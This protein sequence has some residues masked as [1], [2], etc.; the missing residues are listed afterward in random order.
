M[1]K[2]KWVIG[3]GEYNCFLLNPKDNQLYDVSPGLPTKVSGQPSLVIGVTAGLHHY[4]LIDNGGNVWAWG[5]NTWGMAGNGTSGNTINS[6]EQITTDI[7]G[8]SFTN[9]K[10]IVA[11][12]NGEG[13]N[14]EANGF[15]ALKNDGTVWIWGNTQ[16][17]MR[18]DGSAGNLA[19]TRPFQVPGLSGVTDIAAGYWCTAL[20]SNGQVW[21]W[22]AA[23][24]YLYQYMLG[25]GITSPA[26]NKPSKVAQPSSAVAIAQGNYCSYAI[27]TSGSV[28]GWGSDPR[29]YGYP[30]GVSPI[31]APV[32]L[33]KIFNFPSPVE[34]IFCGTV[35]S[36]AI[37][38][39]GSLWAWGDNAL[40]AIGNGQEL[41]F[42]TYTSGGKSAP[43]A[44]DWGAMELPQIAPV[45][46]GK[47][48]SFVNIST[49][50]VDSFYAYAEDINGNLYSWGRN[51]ASVLGN[52]VVEADT[53]IGQLGGLYPNSWDVT[54]I[55]PINP[56][57]LK[58]TS[59]TTSP[60]CVT[61]PS[62]ASCPTIPSSTPAVA[63]AGPAQNLAN[64]ITSA[65]LVGSASGSTVNY[66][67]W[68]QLSGPN[69]A[70]IVLPASQSPVV[71]G[72]VPGT[73]SFQLQTTDNVWRTSTSTVTITVAAVIVSTPS[74]APKTITSVVITFSDGSF[75]T[76][77]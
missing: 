17:S 29:Y 7:N 48:I 35:A 13:S 5:D 70:L 58:S 15:L 12:A 66:W 25:Q 67:N 69:T 45:Q 27:L 14:G 28:I 41:N 51:K 8:N 34:N 44:W 1:S 26:G 72:L 30:A 20:D 50:N 59:L 37:L 19:D 39:D 77:L 61:N 3:T 75:A 2:F 24:K 55:T 11:Y 43:Y 18:G 68:S 10:K 74:P 4:G 60:Y 9:I 63:N 6:P 52:G 73:Y 64:G 62:G 22:G 49:A 33:D 21:T 42:A 23:G 32:V 54:W 16:L 56:F 76:I 57:A 38:S 31:T 53:V 71:N 40:G 65:Q 47:G 36:Y 46:I